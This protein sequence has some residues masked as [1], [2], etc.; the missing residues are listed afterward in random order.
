[1][2]AVIRTSDVRHALGRACHTPG[3]TPHQPF[4]S[5]NRNFVSTSESFGTR[6]TK[7]AARLDQVRAT[8]ENLEGFNR[9]KR[10]QDKSILCYLCLLL[11]E[12]LFREIEPRMSRMTRI[13]QRRLKSPLTS[14]QS[15]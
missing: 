11:F 13:K 1:V 14:V 2:V 7:L 8:I 9:R 15:V 5:P 12:I 6:S 10:R 4:Q 3:Q